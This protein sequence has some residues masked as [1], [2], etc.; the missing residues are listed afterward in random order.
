MMANAKKKAVQKKAAPKVSAKLAATVT[1]QK[2]N[3]KSKAPM[4]VAIMVLVVGLIGAQIYHKARKEASLQFDMT[5]VGRVI[6]TGM[7]DGQGMSPLALQ[8]D[9]EDNLYFLDGQGTDPAR[10]QKFSPSCDFIKKYVPSSA[11]HMIAG[12]ADID[13]DKDGNPWVLLKNSSVVVLD[14]DLKYVKTIPTGVAGP[15]GLGILPDG[16]FVVASQIDNKIV[17]FSPLG[18]KIGEFGA[19]G[20]KSGDVISPLR[21]RATASGLIAVIEN[22]S[23]GLRMKVFGPDFK[24][25]TQ[26]NL[27]GLS[28]AEPVKLGVTK[29]DLMF[30]NDTMGGHGVMIWRLKDGEYLGAS[31]GTTDNQ[32]FISPGSGGANKYSK[33]VFVHSINGL[34][35]CRMPEGK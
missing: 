13:V 8:G 29:D 9:S 22:M 4:I 27:D 3:G 28:W 15:A 31:K 6:S 32:L 1:A 17:V 34:T 35:K 21:L 12:P 33:S 30:C 10:L 2:K 23:G 5:R 24:Q 25:L 16:R 26:F 19:P 11:S 20:T 14:K 7:S 18:Q